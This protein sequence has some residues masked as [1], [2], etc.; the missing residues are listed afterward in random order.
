[1]IHVVLF[2]LQVHEISR[3][4]RQFLNTSCH[5]LSTDLGELAS[6]LKYWVYANV[7]GHLLKGAHQTAHLRPPDI[8]LVYFA[9]K[10]QAPLLAFSNPSHVP[11]LLSKIIFSF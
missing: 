7:H 10:A 6:Q 5:T 4:Y 8:T 2:P 1:M 9:N 11:I 3:L